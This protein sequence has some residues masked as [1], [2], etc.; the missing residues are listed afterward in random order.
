[1]TIYKV[2]FGC[3]YIATGMI[4]DQRWLRK[5]QR[6]RWVPIVKHEDQ[7]CARLSIALPSL[8]GNLELEQGM[9]V[10]AMD[11]VYSFSHKGQFAGRAR[12][13][14]GWFSDDI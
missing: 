14:T 13:D 12:G 2:R 5:P 6:L 7:H 11:R 8:A 1:M 4:G 10:A 3:Y 9:T